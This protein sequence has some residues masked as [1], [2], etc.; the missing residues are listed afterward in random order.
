MLPT[1]E[2]LVH[3]LQLVDALYLADLRSAC[4][5]ELPAQIFLQKARPFL[6][7]RSGLPAEQLTVNRLGNI[8]LSLSIFPPLASVV[9]R[10]PSKEAEGWARDQGLLFAAQ[11]RLTHCF[12]C[13][14]S[15]DVQPAPSC[16]TVFFYPANDSTPGTGMVFH[17]H[18]KRCVI[19]YQ[20][21]GYVRLLD[22][23][24]L[25]A[26]KPAYTP[27][28][29]QHDHLL[30]E[31]TSRRTLIAEQLVQRQWVSF[32]KMAAGYTGVAFAE[33]FLQGNRALQTHHI[34]RNASSLEHLSRQQQLMMVKPQYTTAQA[35]DID[36]AFVRTR[37]TTQLSEGFHSGISWIPGAWGRLFCSTRHGV[38]CNYTVRGF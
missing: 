31:Q 24:P 23:P 12:E 22:V 13:N 33:N 35:C 4:S 15:L 30:W 17:K 28:K 14:G 9:Q 19:K 32:H 21:H 16:G 6:V 11:P 2:E 8:L 27:Y 36:Q 3:P 10:G 7:G 26:S 37:L 18:C 38:S 34:I 1:C 25:G 29:L 20:L 5:A